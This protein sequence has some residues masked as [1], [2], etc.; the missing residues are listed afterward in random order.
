M[1]TRKRYDIACIISH[2]ATRQSLRSVA[3]NLFFSHGPLFKNYKSY[4]LR[5]FTINPGYKFCKIPVP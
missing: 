4:G 5:I 2:S 1:K 3:P